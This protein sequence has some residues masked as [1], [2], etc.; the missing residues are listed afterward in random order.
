MLG[1]DITDSTIGIVGLGKI[2]QT[3]AKRLQGF[4]LK[5]ILYTSRKEKLE[6]NK[7]YNAK[8]VSLDELVE[9]S[10]FIVISI[11]LTNQTRGMFNKMLFDK[12]K[13][14]SVLVNV[15]RGEII[16][17]NDLVDALKNGTIF[18]AGL[19]VMDPEP[20]PADHPL[21]NLP[22]C[23]I[24]PHLGSAT[25]ETRSAMSLIAAHNVLRGLAKEPMLAPV[26]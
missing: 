10:D 22:N 26:P 24:V 23:V 17:T 25:L 2:G 20:L 1:Q 9:K 14:T 16:N 6:A 4:D 13:P 3:I 12:M 18:A 8:F 11:P 21:M 7:K 19:D 15:A 5:Q